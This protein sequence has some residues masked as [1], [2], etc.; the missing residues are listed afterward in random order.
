MKPI[1][2]HKDICRAVAPSG[3]VYGGFDSVNNRYLF[4]RGSYTTGGFFL[5]QCAE[6]DLTVEN[7]ALMAKLG[8]TRE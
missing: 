3:Y 7:L 1:P 2:N 4:Q 6:E 5:M 8:V